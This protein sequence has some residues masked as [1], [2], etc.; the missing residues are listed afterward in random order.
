MKWLKNGA[1]KASGQACGVENYNAKIT[2]LVWYVAAYI[3]QGPVKMI[4]YSSELRLELKISA[5]TNADLCI[6]IYVYVSLCKLVIN[7]CQAKIAC[8]YAGL[9]CSWETRK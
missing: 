8:R 6:V 1:A 3:I 2:M 9:E 7:I 4:L 5:I